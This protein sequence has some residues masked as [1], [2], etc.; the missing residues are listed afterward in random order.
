[1]FS[2]RGFV[3]EE[4]D[5]KNLSR[6]SLEI[7][8]FQFLYGPAYRLTLRADRRGRAIAYDDEWDL[9]DDRKLLLEILFFSCSTWRAKSA[10]VKWPRGGCAS[11]RE[12]G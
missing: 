11:L 4:P 1:M 12:E 8:L 5:V 9:N 10:S 3:F 2:V 6:V 7:V